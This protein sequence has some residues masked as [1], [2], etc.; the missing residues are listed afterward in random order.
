MKFFS[1]HASSEEKSNDIPS[2]I[3]SAVTVMKASGQRN[4]KSSVEVVPVPEKKIATAPRKDSPF[5]GE[6]ASFEAAPPIVAQSLASQAPVRT[7]ESSSRPLSPQ[8][9]VSTAPAALTGQGGKR[10]V[11]LIAA[12]FLLMINL[13]PSIFLDGL[14][15]SNSI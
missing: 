5:L 11:W 4:E 14:M 2:E 15:R 7:S 10:I 1:D 6:G 8:V 9:S 13:M 3:L 12:L